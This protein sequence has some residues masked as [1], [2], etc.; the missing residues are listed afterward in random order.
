[1]LRIGVFSEDYKLQPLLSSAL[2]KEFQI[3]LESREE[4][5]SRLLA[6]ESCDVVILDLDS[7]YG[8]VDR[9]MD[10]CRRIAAHPVPSVVMADDSLR[11]SAIELVRLGSH[12]HCRKPPSVRELKAM[13]Y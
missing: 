9:R 8:S 6:S 3:V 2:G 5:M 13:L 12:G 10:Y 1:M 11:P 4:N 7:N